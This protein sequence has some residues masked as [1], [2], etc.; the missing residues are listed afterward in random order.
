MAGWRPFLFLLTLA[1]ATAASAQS[2]GRVIVPYPP[3]GSL[4]A[5]ARVIAGK[6]SDATGRNF[7]VENRTG[8]AGAIGSA[9]LKGGPT[10]GTLLLFAP[11]SNISVYPP[12]VVK[13][14][15]LPLTDF[16]AVAHSGDYRISFAVHPSVPAKD[17]KGFIAWTKTQPGAVGYGTAGPGGRRSGRRS[18][19]RDRAAP[20]RP[21]RALPERQD[22]HPRANRRAAVRDAARSSL[23][24][25]ARLSAARVFRL[26]R[27]IRAGRDADRH[28]GALQRRDRKS[29]P[30]RR[31]TRAHARLRARAARDE[32]GAVPVLRKSRHRALG[33]DHQGFRVHAERAIRR[34]IRSGVA[35]RGTS[36]TPHGDSASSSAW[37]TA[38]G[39]P[40][41]PASLPPFT[42]RRLVR[43]G[44]RCTSERM[45]GTSSARGIA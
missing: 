18:C 20:R 43:V 2:S 36:V 28:R 26:V 41:F 16:A 12:T 45:S 34:Q 37:T 39:T 4:D 24:Q 23:V 19:P 27:R 21:A 6:L 40:T 5:M 9:S 44:T 32:R 33:S 8:A 30:H 22:P 1:A 7:V 42:P 10:D 15:Y 17:L 38:G 3:G 11:D 31:S 13:P 14:A 25:G 35:G 29:H